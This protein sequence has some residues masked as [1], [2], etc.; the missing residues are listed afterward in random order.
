MKKIIS[1]GIKVTGTI[2]ADIPEY[3]IETLESIEEVSYIHHPSYNKEKS[4]LESKLY[5]F[6][7]NKIQIDDLDWNEIEINDVSNYE[8]N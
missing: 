2:I 1:F 5:E 6:L 7:N 4:E 8:E 3:L